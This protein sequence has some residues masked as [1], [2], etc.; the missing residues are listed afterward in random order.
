MDTKGLEMV[1]TD[2][3]RLDYINN[4][5]KVAGVLATFTQEIRRAEKVIR[6]G[7]GE[8]AAGILVHPVFTE[9]I[10][11]ALKLHKDSS[12]LAERSLYSRCEHRL[13]TYRVSVQQVRCLKSGEVFVG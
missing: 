13:P 8:M 6:I 4:L 3:E 9:R 7:P 5:N 11:S 1:L 12:S 10:N 2:K